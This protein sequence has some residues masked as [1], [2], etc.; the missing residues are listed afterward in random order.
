MSGRTRRRVHYPASVRAQGTNEPSGEP[1]VSI[2]IPSYQGSRWIR[3][4]IGSALTQDYPAIEVV[5]SDDASTDGSAEAA[6]SIGDPRIRVDRSDRRRGLAR[7]WN[8]S[9]QLSKGAYVKFLMQDDLLAPTCV[10][11]MAEVLSRNA[12]VGMVFAP[13]AIR[14]DPP[15]DYAA[16]R[17]GRRLERQAT[18]FSGLGEVTG[19]GVI[20]DAIRKTGLRGNWIGEPTAVMVRRDALRRVG[21]FNAHLHQLTDLEL[22]LRIASFFDVGFVPDVLST[23]TL[24]ATSATSSNRR[25]GAAWLD[26]AWVLEGLRAYPDLRSSFAASTEARVWTGVLMAEV[27]RYLKTGIRAGHSYCPGLRDYLRYRRHPSRDL[28]EAL[29]VVE[30]GK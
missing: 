20:V 13:R 22:W 4:A 12:S 16:A 3:E 24:H 23:F 27:S 25:G 6:E 7:N 14:V 15:G 2:C 9:V 29:D 8:R 19:G 5:V 28:H 18:A 1:L 21:L 10:S 11:R 30:A 26:A 17:L